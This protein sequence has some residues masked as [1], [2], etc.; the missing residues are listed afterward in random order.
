M[1]AQNQTISDLMKLWNMTHDGVLKFIRKNKDKINESGLHIYKDSTGWCVD[2]VGLEELNKLRPVKSD[3]IQEK[4]AVLIREL[5]DEISE[6][7]GQLV[8]E[9]DR[10]M[11]ALAR[12]TE[13]QNQLIEAKEQLLSLPATAAKAEAEKDAALS[14]I[15]FLEQEKNNQ[16]QRITAQE[17]EIQQLKEELQAEAE[18]TRQKEEELR[19]E[20]EKSWLQK[21]LGK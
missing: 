15:E 18:R 1:S 9:K 10:T 7:R 12:L 6:L 8:G 4:E 11:A 21:L 17:L 3:L 20:K 5:R 19:Q 13:S 14:K 2:S 16:N